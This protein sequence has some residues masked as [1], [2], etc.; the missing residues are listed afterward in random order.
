MAKTVIITSSSSVNEHPSFEQLSNYVFKQ[1]PVE[2][3]ME[4]EAHLKVCSKCRT[5]TEGIQTYRKATG[6]T[7]M[8]METYLQAFGQQQEQLIDKHYANAS[9]KQAKG[10]PISGQFGIAK[11]K[12][13]KWCYPIAAMLIGCM[14][15]L[16]SLQFFNFQ[17]SPVVLAEK[18][19]KESFYT[20]LVIRGMGIDTIAEQVWTQAVLAYKRHDFKA[21]VSYIEWL[22]NHYELNDEQRYFR[23]LSHLYFPERDMITAIDQLEVLSQN[24]A[25]FGEQSKWFLS[26][27]YVL[28]DKKHIAQPL[29]EEMVA[30]HSWKHEEAAQL[31]DLVKVK[32]KKR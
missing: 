4:V 31:L 12:R 10:H 6:A 17:R 5:I 29:L 20:P 24:S 7:Q 3:K 28:E 23:A 16:F 8:S 14:M 19:L 11:G 15:I 27:A 32:N 9:Q 30:D 25:R 1:L 18:Q 26:L 22:D 21:A 2:T 13:H